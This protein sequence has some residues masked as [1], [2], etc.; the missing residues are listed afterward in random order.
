MIW[1]FRFFSIAVFVVFLGFMATA[2]QL[3]IHEWRAGYT[4]LY[5]TLPPINWI[6]YYTDVGLDRIIRPFIASKKLGLPKVNLYVPK[7]AQ[8]ALLADVPTS[9]K[10][11]QKGFLLYPDGKL[12]KVKV[13]HR[14]DNAFN[15]FFEKKSWRVKTR[16][17]NL[18]RNTRVINFNSPQSPDFLSE[19]LGYWLG[20]NAGV[21]APRAQMVELYLNDVSNGVLLEV[22]HLDEGYLRNSNLMPIN[23]YKGE[24]YNTERAFQRDNNLFNNPALW[25]KLSLDNANEEINFGDLERFLELVRSAST[26]EIAFDK[27]V[28]VAPI[29]EWARFSAF[30][31]LAQSWGNNY[32]H[33][34][35]LVSDRWRGSVLPVV[36]DTVVNFRNDQVKT[37]DASTQPLLSLYGQHSGF[38]LAKYQQL[39]RMLRKELLLEKLMSHVN[40]LK[41]PLKISLSRDGNRV[42]LVHSLAYIDSKMLTHDGLE[43]QW[44]ELLNNVGQLQS[45]LLEQL[46][47]KP[48]LTWSNVPSGFELTIDG[49]SPA[50]NL[51]L[52][53]DSPNKANDLKFYWDADYS[54]SLSADDIPLPTKTA[55]NHLT[56]N[57]A[58]L[59]NRILFATNDNRPSNFSM[60]R[61]AIIPTKFKIFANSNMVIRSVRGKNPFT[62]KIYQFTQAATDGVTPSK[63]NWPVFDRPGPPL[64]RWAG[65][66]HNDQTQI[67]NN[68]V[69]IAAG[70]KIIM[71]PGTS[72]VFRGKLIANGTAELP[73]T[74]EPL[75]KIRPWGTFALQGSGSNGSRI[76]HLHAA[77][78]SGAHVEG[79]DYTSMVS[80]H[81]TEN[82]VFDGLK[83]ADSK[84]FD[85]M[86]HIIYSQNVEL[87]NFQLK[88]ALGDAL[89][90]DISNIRV[91]DGHITDSG[92]DGI[93]LMSSNALIHRTSVKNSGDKGISIGEKSEAYV[94]RSLLT[95]NVIGVEAKDASHVR[96]VNSDLI[97]NEIQINAYM[98]NWRYGNGGQV[99]IAKTYLS[100]GKIHLKAQKKSKIQVHDSTLVPF[101]R[102]S[103]RISID[104]ISNS[105]NGRSAGI[106]TIGQV[107]KELLK[108]YGLSIINSKRG[109]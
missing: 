39:H 108:K 60:G 28:K 69:Q 25:S 106:Q 41:E 13:R 18:F 26:S 95:R 59:A 16:K 55:G 91:A 103:K 97:D 101:Q 53:L 50:A 51:S 34:M 100:G 3:V 1:R 99:T 82:I 71:S 83:L 89:D 4:T 9:T 35:R 12:R 104:P 19:Y 44:N 58:F 47:K 21:L 36:H 84:I 45:W 70:T 92:N 6:R 33:N 65:T 72:I 20:R 11:W 24:Q 96:I 90:V 98:K 54:N 38:L 52:I 49:T 17:N 14:G 63:R 27:L 40:T 29:L 37:L 5:Q 57:A 43:R 93:D 77:F 32:Q 23:L 15:W 107:G 46:E 31:I 79:V 75:D 74:I 61:T 87:K 85:D 8:E 76:S 64:V 42:Q 10:Y 81:D 102:T 67:F 7:R 80:V 2:A 56:I 30:Q 66:V 86:F 109:R 73:I 68:D 94:V 48:D 105:T 62:G 78:G 22:D 88:N